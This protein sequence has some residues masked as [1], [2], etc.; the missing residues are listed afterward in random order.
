MPYLTKAWHSLDFATF[1]TFYRQTDDYSVVSDKQY[2]VHKAIYDSY[3]SRD[4]AVIC[5]TIYRHYKVSIEK[6]LGDNHMSDTNLSFDIINPDM[7][8]SD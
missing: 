3:L 7:G 8:V 4:C 1:Y 6:L 5:N 2:R